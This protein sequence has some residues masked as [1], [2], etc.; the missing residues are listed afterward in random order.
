MTGP[1]VEYKNTST[2]KLQSVNNAEKEI[3][4]AGREVKVETL[5]LE[6]LSGRLSLPGLL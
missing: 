6:L 2:R 1:M 4:R 3:N 5:T